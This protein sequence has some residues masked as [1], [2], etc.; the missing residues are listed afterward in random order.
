[1]RKYTVAQKLIT[2]SMAAK[3]LT[4]NTEKQRTLSWGW[5]KFLARQITQGQWK[6]NGETIILSYTGKLLQG[7][8]RL[9]AIVMTGIAIESLVVMDMD[10][11]VYGTLDQVKPR[12]PADLL[13]ELGY[14][15]CNRLAATAQF[16][17]R[18]NVGDFNFTGV[19]KFGKFSS[20]EVLGMVEKYPGVCDAIDATRAL[21]RVMPPSAGAGLYYLCAQKDETLAG[22]FY[23]TLGNGVGLKENEPVYQLREKLLK[24]RSGEIDLKSGYIAALT[25][26]AWNLTRTG[27]KVK[28]LKFANDET[29]PNIA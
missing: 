18:Y 3:W 8:H 21:A 6:V 16:I 17:E 20:L 28:G 12:S 1:M 14:K 27:R 29:F 4:T 10:E 15:Y 25:I 11:G 13:K 2:P 26:K 7:Q 5:V 19:R 24:H 9:Q 23:N 22:L